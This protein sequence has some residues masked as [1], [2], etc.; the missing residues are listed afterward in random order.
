[1]KDEFKQHFRNVSRIMDC[2]GCDK[3]RLWGKIQ[4]T[5]LGTALKLLFSGGGG[6]DDIVLSRSE[7]V[8]FVNTLHRLS[9]SLAAVD[10]FR[11]LWAQRGREG[12]ATEQ[13]TEVE[14]EQEVVPNDESKYEDEQMANTTSTLEGGGKRHDLTTLPLFC[15]RAIWTKLVDLCEL[16]LSSLSLG[17]E[18]VANGWRARTASASRTHGDAL[19]GE[20]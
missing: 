7:T 16:S 3:C 5:G 20:L 6:D 9:E 17:S 2:V 1:M 8:A 10:K 19:R 4:V 12:R 15:A 11:D 14:E 13:V 18:V